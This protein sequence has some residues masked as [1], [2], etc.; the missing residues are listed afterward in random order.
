MKTCGKS[1]H[2]FV[3]QTVQLFNLTMISSEKTRLFGELCCCTEA[4]IKI[5]ND[6]FQSLRGS[7]YQVS[8]DIC[9][10]LIWYGAEE[11]TCNYCIY[12]ISHLIFLDS[13]S[14]T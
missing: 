9:E 13:A 7:K 2:H 4:V 3:I 8:H 10:R 11:Q 14:Q 12:V 6:C 5:I 1:L